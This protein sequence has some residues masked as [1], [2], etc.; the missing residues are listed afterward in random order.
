MTLNTLV[1]VGPP[2]L[3]LPDPMWVLDQRHSSILMFVLI[4][5]WVLSQMDLLSRF[6]DSNRVDV[7]ESMSIEDINYEHVNRTCPK[8][9]K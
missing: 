8:N 2:C 5:S 3:I 6:N 7:K 4:T 9:R 1:E